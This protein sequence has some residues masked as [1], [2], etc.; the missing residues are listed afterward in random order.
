MRP[1]A[2]IRKKKPGRILLVSYWYPPAVG[3]AA[4]RACGFAR[5]LPEYGWEVDVL[6]VQRT[7]E[8]PKRPGLRV[9]G[10]AD[11]LRPGESTFSDYDPSR[12]AGRVVSFLRDRVFPDRF[13]RWRTEA[14]RSAAEW[15]RARRFDWILASFPPASAV[16]LALDLREAAGARLILDYRD[17]WIG[18]GGYTPRREKTRLAHEA[19]E[20]S[21]VE[22]ATLILT[23]SEAMADAIAESPGCDRSKIIVIP[24]GYSVPEDASPDEESPEIDP[25]PLANREDDDPTTNTG[26]TR[27]TVIAHVGTVIARNRPDLFFDALTELQTDARLNK[28]VFRFVGNLSRAYVE[29]AGLSSIVETTGLLSRECAHREM[30]DA[31]AL[32]LLTGDYVGHW[33]YSA[34]LFEYVQTGRP[35]LCLE[36]TPGSNDRKLLEQFVRDRAFFAPAGDADAMAERIVELKAYLAEHPNAALHLAPAFRDYSRASLAREL[37]SRLDALS[38]A[39]R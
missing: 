35:I 25:G 16:Q 5:H 29:T 13:V 11:P 26:A 10:V 30:Q 20:R 8:P 38:P 39:P 31:D 27:P 9:H 22:Q 1:V 24:N 6:T 7:P 21:A 34:K 36:E 14:G 12:K 3:A 32:L 17:C 4:E 19:L 33:G 28:V 15:V 2:T 37:A 23:V 18:P